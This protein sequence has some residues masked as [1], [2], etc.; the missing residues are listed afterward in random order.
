MNYEVTF[1][2]A[3]VSCNHEAYIAVLQNVAEGSISPVPVDDQTSLSC[4]VQYVTFPPQRRSKIH[5]WSVLS[6][7]SAYFC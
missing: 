5:D 1:L 7:K 2:E 4:L 6:C 3:F